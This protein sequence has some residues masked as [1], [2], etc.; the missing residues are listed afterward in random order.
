[1]ATI[2]ENDG[3]NPYDCFARIRR[4][5]GTD[6]PKKALNW[7]FTVPVQF[8]IHPPPPPNTTMCN[9]KCHLCSGRNMVQD[10]QND[11]IPTLMAL[12]QELGNT[13]PEMVLAGA[14]TEPMRNP[15][16]WNILTLAHSLGIATIT[17][18]NASL[19]VRDEAKLVHFL[20]LPGHTQNTTFSL[21]IYGGNE[22]GF[23]QVTGTSAESGLFGDVIEG[24]KL[25]CRVKRELKSPVSVRF[26]YL[27]SPPNFHEG[28]IAFIRNI[29]EAYQPT[30]MR[31]ALA[32]TPYATSFDK[33]RGHEE[34]QLRME[35][36]AKEWLTPLLKNN[37]GVFYRYKPVD[38]QS[39]N[40]F[41]NIDKCRFT[42]FKINAAIDG[43]L[44]KCSSVTTGKTHS[45]GPLPDNKAEFFDILRRSQDP[46]FDPRSSCFDCGH[47]CNDSGVQLNTNG[48]FESYLEN[49]C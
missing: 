35:D 31:V 11:W 48:A 42:T 37:G 43:E 25:I 33:V 32:F 2:A 1:M 44:Y 47:R 21:S 49:Y 17:H 24:L 39:V 28:Q 4:I 23:H 40:L 30:S 13:I 22:R 15:D 14:K 16:Y 10:A 5:R 29:A 3:Y 45:Y 19:L 9:F 8:E 38:R 27:G 18:T 12:M 6:G 7:D 46:N 26:N 41:D 36:G 34:V 20:S